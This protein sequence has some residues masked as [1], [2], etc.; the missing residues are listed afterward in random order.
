MASR[1]KLTSQ[2]K[3]VEESKD[4]ACP[5]DKNQAILNVP[6]NDVKTDTSDFS[7]TDTNTGDA[8]LNT[9]DPGEEAVAD[10]HEAKTRRK[11]KAKKPAQPAQPV[12]Q[13]KC[14]RARGCG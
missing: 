14:V 11:K 10:P 1:K 7:A 5:L 12:V 13:G 6:Y 8:D 3:E 9:V 4:N 2:V